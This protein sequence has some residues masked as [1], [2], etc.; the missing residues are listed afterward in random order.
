MFKAHNS[1]SH[2]Q[3][4]L[5]SQSAGRA[6]HAVH[7]ECSYSLHSKTAFGQAMPTLQKV[8]YPIKP[9][10]LMYSSG[11]TASPTSLYCHV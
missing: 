6:C 8:T 1:T 7:S 2:G 4:Y 11:I 10:L 3:Q 5:Q 9:P